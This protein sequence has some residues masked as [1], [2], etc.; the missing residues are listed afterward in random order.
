MTKVVMNHQL[1]Y[2]CATGI[3]LQQL[4]ISRLPVPVVYS[5]S[6]HQLW[7]AG[8]CARGLQAIARNAILQQV[9]VEHVAGLT[10]VS[11]I[12]GIQL[13]ALQPLWKISPPTHT[14]SASSHHRHRCRRQH[15]RRLRTRRSATA[16]A[17]QARSLSRRAPCTI[18]L[19][20]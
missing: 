17:V 8:L 14:T 12:I 3:E 19:R 18:T 16:D 1:M 9:S 7:I 10:A 4:S 13:N 11:I 2:G 20:H 15:H 6:R 5:R